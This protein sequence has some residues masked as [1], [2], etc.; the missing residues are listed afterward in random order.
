MYKYTHELSFIEH[1]LGSRH[2]D[3]YFTDTILFNSHN[4][5]L[6]IGAIIIFTYS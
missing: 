5:H 2:Y 4:N 6:R 1:I 3:N